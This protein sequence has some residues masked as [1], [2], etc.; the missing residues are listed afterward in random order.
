MK[1]LIFLIAMLP[2]IAVADSLT[3]W[4]EWNNPNVEDGV[5]YPEAL[6]FDDMVSVNETES[7]AEYSLP[8][9]AGDSAL[10]DPGGTL[11][12]AIQE[13]IDSGT[14]LDTIINDLND[15]TIPCLGILC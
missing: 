6:P 5:L 10:L 14:P 15:G 11:G 13:L 12:D 4:G 2:S 7:L 1:D 8:I 9:E 3:D